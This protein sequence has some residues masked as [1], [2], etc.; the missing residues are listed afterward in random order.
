[1]NTVAKS[2]EHH[3]KAYERTLTA[4]SWTDLG[5]DWVAIVRSNLKAE[6][7]G[8]EAPVSIDGESKEKAESGEEAKRIW[9]ESWE[10]RWERMR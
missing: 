9:L 8:V 6:K 5:W 7:K 1:M 10:K 4:K 2:D 3:L